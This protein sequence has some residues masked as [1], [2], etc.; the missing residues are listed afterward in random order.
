MRPKI[1][2]SYRPHGKWGDFVAAVIPTIWCL[3]ILA[4]SNFILRLIEWQNESS[5]FTIRVRARQ[6]YWLYKFELKAFSDILSAPKNI[7]HNR[8]VLNTF[9]DLQTSD[10]YLHILQ[11]RSQAKWLKNYWGELLKEADNLEINNVGQYKNRPNIVD[12]HIAR[13]D[14][15]MR[16]NSFRFPG[17]LDNIIIK[18]FEHRTLNW[19][20]NF[21]SLDKTIYSFLNYSDFIENS[22]LVKKNNGVDLPIRLIKFPLDLL[23]NNLIADE[24]TL[25]KL[26]FSSGKTALTHKIAPHSTYLAFKQ[27][28][29]KRK[30]KYI[31]IK[32]I[33][34]IWYW[35]YKAEM[36]PS[37]NK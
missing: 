11:L 29:Y 1:V 30:K 4:N 15:N 2:T 18:N 22:R 26:R 34:N 6:W 35:K 27:K 17:A 13:A 10:D 33:N 9:G 7:G 23:E 3:N 16:K 21:N 36:E 5:L 31:T 8:W 20:L 28:R 37:A 24:G 25:F 12:K 19:G 32:Q 14:V